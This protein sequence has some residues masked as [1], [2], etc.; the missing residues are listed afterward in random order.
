[1][2]SVA[3]TFPFTVTEVGLRLQVIPVGPL[4]AR[5]TEALKPLMEPRFSVDVP[6]APEATVTTGVSA[7]MEKSDRGLE[8]E[9]VAWDWV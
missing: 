9:T 7:T 2:V 6:V 4:Q 8:S 3:V 1:M 5:P